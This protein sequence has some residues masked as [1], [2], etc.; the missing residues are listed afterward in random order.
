VFEVALVYRLFSNDLFQDNFGIISFGHD[1]KSSLLN[2]GGNK[3]IYESITLR[4]RGDLPSTVK[5]VSKRSE[6]ISENDEDRFIDTL[7]NNSEQNND[8]GIVNLYGSDVI[9]H[10]LETCKNFYD[11]VKGEDRLIAPS[12]MFNTGTNL[13]EQLLTKNCYMKDRRNKKN[14]FIW[15]T[16]ATGILKQVPWGKHNPISWRKNHTAK[17]ASTT[18]KYEQVLPVFIIKDPYTWMGSLCR[19]HYSA[20]WP[21]NVKHCP[22]LIANHNDLRVRNGQTVPFRIKYTNTIKYNY[23]SMVQPWNEWYRDVL[24][25]NFP[26][27]IIRFEDLLFHTKEIVQQI[28]ECGGGKLINK[29]FQYIEDSAKGQQKAHNGAN[30]RLSALTRYSNHSLRI[31]G[32]SQDD[33]D[34]ASNYLDIDLMRKFG[35]NVE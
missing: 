22:N 30:G 3:H 20:L 13:M 1:V 18:I 25:T 12:G 27:L 16:G 28:C 2:H 26:R 17:E 7:E 14:M 32:F 31:H 4:D 35:Y 6:P 8:Y 23:V 5:K 29:P 33:L 19:H 24:K 34:Y 21:H 9:I 10:G 15:S 11:T